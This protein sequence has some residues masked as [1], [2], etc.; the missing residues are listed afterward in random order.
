MQES[1]RLVTFADETVVSVEE[2][3]AN[4]RQSVDV[5]VCTG[6][7]RNTDLWHKDKNVSKK[8][9]RKGKDGV[10]WGREGLQVYSCEDGKT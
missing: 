1:S 7:K 5:D 6:E 4:E 9:G 2:E 3:E 8:G 10:S